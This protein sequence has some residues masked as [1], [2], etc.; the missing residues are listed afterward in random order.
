ML[1]STRLL[2]LSPAVSLLLAVTAFG[3]PQAP[4]AAQAPRG[5]QLNVLQQEYLDQVLD[6]WQ[7]K[8][9]QIETFRCP[10]VRW[11]YN[12]AFGPG[13]NSPLFVKQGEVSFE[14]PDKGSFHITEV[15]KWDQNARTYVVDP[16]IVGERWV[17]DGQN[18]YE[19]RHQ[20]KQLVVRPIPPELQ[21]KAIVD[22]PLPFLFGAESAKLKQRYWLRVDDTQGIVG[23]QG[24]TNPNEIWIEALPR[25]RADAAN[26]TKVQ[27][28]L[29]RNQWLPKAMQVHLPDGNRNSYQFDLTQASINSRWE[30]FKQWF[31]PPEIL[32]G[33]QRVVEEMPPQTADPR[34][35]QAPP[36][37]PQR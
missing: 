25:H 22:G 19:Y 13:P 3:Q 5:F 28:I 33:W 24:E 20:Q 31:Q 1:R 37:A 29:D 34:L 36:S 12:Q 11:D 23:G 2:L 21:G 32:P 35:G 15:K 27:L 26:Y 10:F 8:T 6:K 7:Q 4:P 16:Q 14:R 30:R 18:I 9:A 17:C